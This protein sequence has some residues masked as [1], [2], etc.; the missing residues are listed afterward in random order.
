MIGVVVFRSLITYKLVFFSASRQDSPVAPQDMHSEAPT[1]ISLIYTSSYYVCFIRGFVSFVSFTVAV[2]FIR[3]SASE[4]HI[5][6]L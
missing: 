6:Y 2:K 3:M 1:T 4:S 5:M